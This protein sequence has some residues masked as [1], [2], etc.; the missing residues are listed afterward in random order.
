MKITNAKLSNSVDSVDSEGVDRR[1]S[2]RKPLCI[3]V[4]VYLNNE[5]DSVFATTVDWSDNGAR[6]LFTTEVDVPDRFFFRKVKQLSMSNI[7]QCRRVWQAGTEVG[8]VF[9]DAGEH[10]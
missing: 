10:T 7:I 4:L 2:D 9:V 3:N 8:V 5:S 6:I 1:N